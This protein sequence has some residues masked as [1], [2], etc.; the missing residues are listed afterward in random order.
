V[1]RNPGQPGRELRAP[2]E[3]RE[4]RIRIHVRFLHHVL[5]LALVAD[6]GARGAIDAFVMAPHQDLEDRRVAIEDPRH[7]LL[8][9]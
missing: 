6:D 8:V 3:L 2:I 1:H 9:R 4:V 5:G 7:D